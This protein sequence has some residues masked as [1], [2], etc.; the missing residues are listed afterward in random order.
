MTAAGDYIPDAD[1]DLRRRQL[2]RWPTGV[3]VITTLGTGGVPLGKAANSF[4]TVSLRP[5]LVGWCVD[6]ASTRY[7]EWLTAA[8]YVVHV[9]GAGHEQYMRQFATTGRDKF[10]GVD[11]R[12]GLDGMPVLGL[13]VPLRLECR[14]V[15]RMPAGDH[16]YLIAEVITAAEG[17]GPAL[18]IE[19]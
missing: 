17:P 3:A 1:P 16:T 8:G 2:A 7:Q 14:V 9:L 4:H 19:K 15:H 13:C 18:V 11:W 12:P 6:H 5:A 10:G